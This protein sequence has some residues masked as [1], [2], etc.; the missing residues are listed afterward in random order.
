MVVVGV[1]HPLRHELPVLPPPFQPAPPLEQHGLQPGGGERGLR[2]AASA[3]TPTAS[4]DTHTNGSAAFPHLRRRPAVSMTAPGGNRVPRERPWGSST[5][6][7]SGLYVFADF[8]M[9]RP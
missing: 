7:D 5:S 3:P 2:Y 1:G 6:T 8:D 4:S 9:Q